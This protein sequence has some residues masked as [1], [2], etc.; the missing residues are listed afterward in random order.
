MSM[1]K[2][3]KGAITPSKS[4]YNSHSSHDNGKHIEHSYVE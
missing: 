3:P 4:T 2:Q 1:E